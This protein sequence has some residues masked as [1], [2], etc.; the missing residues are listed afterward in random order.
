MLGRAHSLLLMLVSGWLVLITAPTFLVEQYPFTARSIYFLFADICHQIPERSFQVSGTQL[1]VCHR[2]VGIYLGFWLGVLCWPWLRHLGQL[3]LR[4]P[5][6]ILLPLVLVVINALTFSTPLER[7]VTGLLAGFPAA[8]FVWIAFEQLVEAAT[9]VES[10]EGR[11]AAA[12]GPNARQTTD[13]DP[14]GTIVQDSHRKPSEKPYVS[15]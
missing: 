14:W 7:V 1:A 13:A 15:S 12:V 5:R 8:L 3:L 9:S 2:C 10:P 4:K 6:L 11:V